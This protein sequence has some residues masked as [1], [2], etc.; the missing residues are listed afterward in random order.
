LPFKR[1][2]EKKIIKENFFSFLINTIAPLHICPRHWL[3]T[4][5][6]FVAII[7]RLLWTKHSSH[8]NRISLLSLVVSLQY[9]VRTH[10]VPFYIFAIHTTGDMKQ[11]FTIFMISRFAKERKRPRGRFLYTK[12]KN[13]I[14]LYVR[15]AKKRSNKKK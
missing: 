1:W 9:I 10:D 13:K 5:H 4:I 12:N 7:T 14:S 6:T 11:N 2:N 3:L 8:C 15:A